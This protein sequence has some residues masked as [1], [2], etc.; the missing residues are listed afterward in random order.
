MDRLTF[1]ADAPADRVRAAYETHG[2]VMMRALAPARLVAELREAITGM[3]KARLTSLEEPVPEGDLDTVYERLCAVDRK[4]AG[5]VYDHVKDLAE[6]YRLI[7]APAICEVVAGLLGSS[8]FQM[9]LDLC[10][11]RIDRRGE[12]RFAFDWHQDYPYNLISQNAVT[13]WIPLTDVQPE[14]GR[15]KVVLGSHRERLRITVREP[16]FV[17]GMGGGGRAIELAGIDREAL[18]AKARDVDARA[19]DVLLFHTYLLH[20]S[21]KNESPRARWTANPRYGDML[22]GAMV[23]RG[24]RS[25]TRKDFFIQP[26]IHPEDA[27][28]T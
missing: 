1:D 10:L 27:E 24:W 19:G 12:D 6:Y 5:S 13:A 16:D 7:S 20:R 21:G 14:M 22:D 25:V 17:P 26:E 8:T 23:A 28:E 4:A 18:D 2:A 15:L 11:F 3:A 9:P